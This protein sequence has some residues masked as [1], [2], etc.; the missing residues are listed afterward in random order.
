MKTALLLV[1]GAICMSAWQAN[2]ADTISNPSPTTSETVTTSQGPDFSGH[3]MSGGA[4][5][6]FGKNRAEVYQDLVRSKNDG[7][8]ARIQQLYRGGQ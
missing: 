3:S 2:A 6:P 4:A 7:G 1:G 5:L 8:A